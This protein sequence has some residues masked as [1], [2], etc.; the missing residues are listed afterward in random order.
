MTQEPFLFSNTVRFNADPLGEH[1]D[2]EIMNSLKRVGLW[3][4]FVEKATDGSDPLDVMM[5]ESMLS[6]GQRQLF[7]LGRALLK[8]TAMLILDEPTS[9]Y[10]ASLVL[11]LAHSTYSNI[12]L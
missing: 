5:T 4:I 8:K 2:Q 11:A 12:T 10:V 6:H 7:C 3:Y 9:R 1:G